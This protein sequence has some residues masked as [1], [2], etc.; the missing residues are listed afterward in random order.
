MAVDRVET[1]SERAGFKMTAENA[2]DVILINSDSFGSAR[3]APYDRWENLVAGARSN[4][5]TFTKVVGRKQITRIATRFINRFDIPTE[6]IEGHSFAKFV[7]VGV[8]LPIA[9]SHVIGDYSLAVTGFEV[10]TGAKFLIQNGTVPPALLDHISISLDI[11]AYWDSEIP[12]RI[13]E[14]WEKAETLR[15]AK[16]AIFENCITDEMRE[17]IQ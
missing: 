4:F 15:D 8:S 12:T 1:N 6:K 16:N 17:L 7:R 14:I 13:E 9:V 3:L 2:I 11:D 10:S 5:E